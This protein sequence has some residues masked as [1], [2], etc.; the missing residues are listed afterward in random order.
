[1]VNMLTRFVCFFILFGVSH[2]MEYFWHYEQG[3]AFFDLSTS[4]VA[5]ACII[6]VFSVISGNNYIKVNRSHQILNLIFSVFIIFNASNMATILFDVNFNTAYQLMFFG[7]C[8]CTF[9][10]ENN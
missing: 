9:D 1:M 4:L 5:I 7:R 3:K 6:Y 8:L 2:L 10:I